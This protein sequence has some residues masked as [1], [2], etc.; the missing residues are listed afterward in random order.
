[1]KYFTSLETG[2]GLNALSHNPCDLLDFQLLVLPAVSSTFL[3]LESVR[4]WR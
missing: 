4:C 2:Q 1:M 3:T